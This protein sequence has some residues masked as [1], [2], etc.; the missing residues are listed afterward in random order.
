MSWPTGDPEAQIRIIDNRLENV[1]AAI[2][3]ATAIDDLVCVAIAE[4]RR[5][6]LLDTRLKI[7][8]TL[9]KPRETPE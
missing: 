6:E 5:D 3:E 9:P 8:A 4:A 1:T 7:M 2:A